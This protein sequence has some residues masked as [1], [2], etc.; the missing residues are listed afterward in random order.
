MAAWS[1]DGT[2]MGALWKPLWCQRC[3]ICKQSCSTMTTCSSIWIETWPFSRILARRIL[4]SNDPKRRMIENGR[5]TDQITNG[6]VRQQ[7]Q[8]PPVRLRSPTTHQ[9]ASPLVRSHRPTSRFTSNSSS[10]L[11]R[12]E[13]C[14]MEN[15]TE[16]RTRD[17][18][19]SSKKI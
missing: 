12:P 19:E 6:D 8:Q 17:E 4:V 9:N 1:S 14:R 10:Y 2:V 7:A 18:W 3:I 13:E 15:I 5:W 16:P 11:F